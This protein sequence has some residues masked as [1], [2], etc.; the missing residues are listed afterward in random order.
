MNR[1]KPIKL[2]SDFNEVVGDDDSLIGEF[3]GDIP[4]KDTSYIV[5]KNLLNLDGK[6]S[7]ISKSKMRYL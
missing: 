3:I 1:K 6:V 7:P 2:S 4:S 5:I